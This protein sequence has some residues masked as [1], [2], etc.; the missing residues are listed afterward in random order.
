LLGTGSW[1]FTVL[2]GLFL[3]PWFL[4]PFLGIGSG[5]SRDSRDSRDSCDSHGSCVTQFGSKYKK[6]EPELE[7]E[8]LPSLLHL[9]KEDRK[10]G[11]SELP[12]VAEAKDRS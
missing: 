2:V 12:R 7:P 9:Y 6:L 5:G 3:E 4:V 8:T 10:T 1:F 11:S